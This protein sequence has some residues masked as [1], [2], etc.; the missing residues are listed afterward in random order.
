MK[1]NEVLVIIDAQN[2]FITG[3][4]YNAEAIKRVDN[5]VNLIKNFKGRHII[6]TQDT[7]WEGHPLYHNYPNTLEGK[8]LPIKHCIKGTFGWQINRKIQKAI[9][10]KQNK[11]DIKIHKILKFHFGSYENLP[12]RLEFLDITQEIDKIVICGFDTDV[13]VISN[14]LI[15]KAFMSETPIE[16]IENCCAGTTAEK[17]QAALQVMESCQIK[18]IKGENE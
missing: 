8:N 12:E 14:A 10:Q 9:E 3:S 16:V 15:L 6:L 1:N 17:H 13:C 7:H 4:L 5:I 11:D 18:I 2:D